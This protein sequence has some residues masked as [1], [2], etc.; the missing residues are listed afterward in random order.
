[1]T[2]T[3][4][5]DE[6]PV[7]RDALAE[8]VSAASESAGAQ[9]QQAPL[10]PSDTGLAQDGQDEKAHDGKAQAEAPVAGEPTY[11]KDT[12]S[13][14]NRALARTSLAM[15]AGTLVSRFLGMIRAALQTAV[16]GALTLAGNAWE[17]AN[18]LPNI[19]F[20][21]LAGGVLNA[22]LVPQ[23][24]RAAKH[25]DGGRD[26]TDRLLTLFL[27][28][29]LLLTIVATAGVTWLVVLYAGSNFSDSTFDLAV[30]FA[31][32]CMPQVFFYGLYT[33][34]GQVLAA[35]NRF[36]AFM[37]A[38]VLA[39]V[40][41]IA[42]MV[43][44]LR[45]FP[46]QADPAD[47]TSDMIWLLA[48]SATAGIVAQ[49]LV[50]VVPLWRSGFRYRPRFGFRG[51]G[52][53]TASRVALWT[54]AALAVS[55]SG[56][57]VTSQ[58]LTRVPAEE[59]GR[60]ASGQAFLLFM[61]PHSLVTV[62]LVT[63]LFT[64]M[65]RAAA[66]RDLPEVRRDVLRGIG[67]SGVAT[68]PATVGGIVLATAVTGTLYVTQSRAEQVGIAQIMA[69]ML[70]GLV[71]FGV[72]YLMQR[73]FYAFEDAR[74]PFVLQV[75]VTGVN[76]GITLCA[77]LV[78]TA[79]IAIVNGFALAASNAVGAVVALV[80]VRRLLEGLR[81]YDVVRSYVRLS[82]AALLAGLLTWGAAAWLRTLVTGPLQ[83]PAVLA[84]GGLL[85]LLVYLALARVM[86]VA[87]VDQLLGPVLARARRLRGG[88]GARLG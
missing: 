28:I 74:T 1:M 17:V 23:L 63:A 59:P 6:Q 26:Y 83:G 42:G 7:D 48:G 73:V 22:V 16:L 36:V 57:I 88:A 72:F 55:Q 84:V 67:L 60:Y 51:V 76:V 29:T 13:A 39:N 32:I 81:L 31:V 21:L 9:E 54:F 41:A 34:L 46:S 35:R 61:L 77:L 87:E 18:S 78:P 3:D 62:S 53:G 58:V 85:F 50:L 4:D 37:W 68:I 56:F 12:V 52:L 45:R 80:L 11:E 27:G 10:P 44:F 75:L 65:S 2:T 40:V 47:W 14:S 24:T 71:P 49:A 82:I 79:Y 38:P 30:A 20:L 33:V 86:R 5:R 70:T 66:V 8:Q 69:A 64:R 43:A 15:S 25:R 19:I